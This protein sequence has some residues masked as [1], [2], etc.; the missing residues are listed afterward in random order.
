MVDG[1]DLALAKAQGSEKT[2]KEYSPQWVAAQD[3]NIKISEGYTVAF[4][5][6]ETSNLMISAKARKRTLDLASY[7]KANQY[8]GCHGPGFRHWVKSDAVPLFLNT[9][10][11][12]LDGKYSTSLEPLPMASLAFPPGS[13][14]PGQPVILV[15]WLLF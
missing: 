5:Q 8:L 7:P 3:K 2:S 4:G 6:A 15:T 1:P 11:L 14:P 12:T 10:E 13:E 9:A